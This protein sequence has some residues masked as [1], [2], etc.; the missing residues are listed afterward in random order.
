MKT[1]LRLLFLIVV[2]GLGVWAWTIFFPKPETIVRKRLSQLAALASF[3]AGEGNFAKVARIERLG[4]L[5]ADQVEVRVD[6]PGF[7]AHSFDRREDLMQVAM[8]VAMDTK[9]VP[10]GI[11]AEFLDIM[12]E[13]GP[14]KKSALVD[15]TLNAKIGD[16]RDMVVQELK[17]TL[18][19][20]KGNWLVTRIETVKT[21][22]L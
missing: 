10:T 2:L 13:V 5:F 6:V 15:L 7:E 22:R 8:Q 16:D 9:Q 12:V 18:K 20:L 21:L 19:N 14:D 17:I 1:L 11:K 4:A 3:S